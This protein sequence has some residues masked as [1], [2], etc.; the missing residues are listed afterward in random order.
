[1]GL[2]LDDNGNR[3]MVGCWG[4]DSHL[5]ERVSADSRKQFREDE[6]LL[7]ALYQSPRT[8]QDRRVPF[9]GVEDITSIVTRYREA[10]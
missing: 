4:E 3:I 2:T 1:M 10:V 7:W 8:R 5:C 9:G 6:Q